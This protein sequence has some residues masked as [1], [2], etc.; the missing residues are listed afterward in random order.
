[1]RCAPSLRASGME[2]LPPSTRKSAPLAYREERATL[3]LVT[4][5]NRDDFTERSFAKGTF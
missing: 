2:E 5:G 1:M 3:I 4:E